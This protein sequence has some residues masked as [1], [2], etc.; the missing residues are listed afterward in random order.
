MK[1][2][3]DQGIA[4]V[5]VLVMMIIFGLVGA[6]ILFYAQGSIAIGYKDIHKVKAYYVAEAGLQRG[7]YDANRGITGTPPPL[8]ISVGKQWVSVEYTITPNP[9]GTTK[10]KANVPNINNIKVFFD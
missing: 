5:F 9:D 6:G 1:N 4:L 3:T 2:N 7:V 10:I 8:Q